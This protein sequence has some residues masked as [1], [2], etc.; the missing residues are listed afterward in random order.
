MTQLT[1]LLKQA[2]SKEDVTFFDVKQKVTALV[3]APLSFDQRKEGWLNVFGRE[4]PNTGKKE[5]T[6]DFWIERSAN[7][8][9]ALFLCF[10]NGLKIE[11]R[12]HNISFGAY[13]SKATVDQTKAVQTI[14]MAANHLCRRGDRLEVGSNY[15][16]A[17]PYMQAFEK[18][19][20]EARTMI[21][22]EQL[23]KIA[24]AAKE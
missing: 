4:N 14:R 20:K 5:T 16:G 13:V 12:D 9:N 3:R 1:T 7:D 11:D 23:R 8:A 2:R 6:D 10:S 18:A 22:Q 21:S 15:S 19:S 17:A 24:T